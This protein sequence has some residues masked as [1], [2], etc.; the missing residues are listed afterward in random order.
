M[1]L[2]VFR[3]YESAR[4][5]NDS[6]ISS[7]SKL[8]GRS[9]AGGTGGSLGWNVSLFDSFIPIKVEYSFK[10]LAIVFSS[11]TGFSSEIIHDWFVPD[12]IS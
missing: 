9:V 11:V 8:C 3:N 12:L 2:L 5:T 4:R 7:K 10:I 1:A 6:S